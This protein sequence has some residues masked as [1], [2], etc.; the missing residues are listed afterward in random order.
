MVDEDQDQLPTI[1]TLSQ[2]KQ[3]AAFQSVGSGTG[4]DVPANH[5]TRLESLATLPVQ[6]QM[7]ASKPPGQRTL[8]RP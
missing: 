8:V 7:Q 4:F 1:K 2:A 3:K 5:A 6:H